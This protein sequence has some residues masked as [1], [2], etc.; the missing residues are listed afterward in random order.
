MIKA[1]CAELLTK[2]TPA[3]IKRIVQADRFIFLI[4]ICM[5]EESSWLCLCWIPDCTYMNVRDPPSGIPSIAEAF[6]FGEQLRNLLKGLA[7]IEVC[8]LELSFWMTFFFLEKLH[9]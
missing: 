6:S 5:V 1:V 7:I 3:K 4:A 8:E 9:Y 2:W